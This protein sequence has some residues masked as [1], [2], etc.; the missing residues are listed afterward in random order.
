M[1]LVLKAYA[2]VVVDNLNTY[3]TDALRLWVVQALLAL[4][5]PRAV[6]L[7]AI[8]VDDLT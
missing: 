6:S 7:R 3:G 8:G 1:L 4:V 5:R 2:I